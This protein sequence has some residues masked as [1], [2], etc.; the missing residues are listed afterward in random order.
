MDRF[1]VGRYEIEKE[2]VK[3]G[4]GFIYF[5]KAPHRRQ[6]VIKVLVYV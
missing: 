2:L 4:M 5:A 1:A 3:G 6:I